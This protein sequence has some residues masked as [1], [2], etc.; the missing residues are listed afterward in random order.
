[1]FS[2]FCCA[3]SL[4]PRPVPCECSPAHLSNRWEKR[5]RASL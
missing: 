5:T 4:R 2:S 1:L 3:F